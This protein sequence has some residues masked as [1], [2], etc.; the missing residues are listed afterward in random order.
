LAEGSVLKIVNNVSIDT[1]LL[2]H[3][4]SESNSFSQCHFQVGPTRCPRGST[5]AEPW[6]GLPGQGINPTTGRPA[7]EF[8]VR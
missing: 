1:R 5:R 6:T 2:D 8:V 3:V 7:D 4:V